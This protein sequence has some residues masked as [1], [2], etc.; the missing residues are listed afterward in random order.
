M[1]PT[2]TW[3]GK[4]E[5]SDAGIVTISN[6]IWHM[7]R[8]GRDGAWLLRQKVDSLAIS[9]DASRTGPWK[10]AR[11]LSNCHIGHAGSLGLCLESTPKLPLCFCGTC[12]VVVITWRS[13]ALAEETFV[14]F[15]L[16]VL[17]DFAAWAT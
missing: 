15:R 1:D 5:V 2:K 3:M 11:L 4:E 14:G 7:Y 16:T 17:G 9:A 6:Y 8:W 10:G 12:E 13:C